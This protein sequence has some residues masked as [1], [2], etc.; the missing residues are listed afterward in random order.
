MAEAAGRGA[1]WQSIAAANGIENPRRLA[2]GRL[3]DL[4]LSTIKGALP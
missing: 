3:L 4:G 1:D 2:A